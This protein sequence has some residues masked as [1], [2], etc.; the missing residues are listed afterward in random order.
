MTT[1][2]VREFAAF[3]ALVVAAFVVRNAG[4]LIALAALAL[5]ALTTG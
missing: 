3:P 1:K 5:G 2:V 4:V